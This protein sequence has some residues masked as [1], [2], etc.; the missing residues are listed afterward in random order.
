MFE[1]KIYNIYNIIN[2]RHDK[3]QPVPKKTS[4]SRIGCMN[5]KKKDNER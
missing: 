1:A 5:E 4:R 2:K 3:L